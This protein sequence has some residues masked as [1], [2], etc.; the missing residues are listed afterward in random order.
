MNQNGVKIGTIRAICGTFMI[1]S[2]V[3][4]VRIWRTESSKLPYRLAKSHHQ[5]YVHD[6]TK[7]NISRRI[8]WFISLTLI[9]DDGAHISVLF[10]CDEISTDSLADE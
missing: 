4:L 1:S 6:E 10:F 2:K 8:F 9:Y 3:P 7:L 5:I